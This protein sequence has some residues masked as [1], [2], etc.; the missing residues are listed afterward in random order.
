MIELEKQYQGKEL[1]IVLN[2]IKNGYPVQYAIGNVNFYGNYI[3][4]NENVLIPRYETEFL[5]DL[6]SKTINKS[7]SG[8]I[9]D[10]GTGSGC[11]AISLA[12][13]FPDSDVT[14]IDISMEAIKVA[15]KN[16]INNK[17]TN[18]T[19]KQKDI[20]NIKN[21][22]LFNIVVSNPPYVSIEEETGKE[23]KYEPQN[24]I[25]AIDNGLYYY[26]KIIEKISKTKIKPEH[27]FFE[28][29][30]KQAEMIEKLCTDLLQNY[31]CKIFKDLSGKDRY[32]HIYMNK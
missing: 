32:I 12:K 22:D 13:I 30:M 31:S 6:I 14:G 10:L 16:K 2:R 20:N 3:E 1:D 21:F 25:F 19:F 24:A 17:V 9:I 5:I 11:I 26:K 8:S 28:I 4:V 27:V 15:E 23:T 29:G 7:F 18:V